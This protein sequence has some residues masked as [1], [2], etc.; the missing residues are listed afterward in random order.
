MK[1]K[2]YKIIFLFTILWQKE[3]SNFE[4][5]TSFNA[6][7]LIKSIFKINGDVHLHIDEQ[8]TSGGIHTF[9]KTTVGTQTNTLLYWPMAT[10]KKYSSIAIIDHN[11]QHKENIQQK[12]TFFIII[13]CLHMN[14]VFVINKIKLLD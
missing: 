14:A 1:L 10:C 11:L 7:L 3:S 5:L 6:P 12:Y 2:F 8:R 9:S 13:K 4:L